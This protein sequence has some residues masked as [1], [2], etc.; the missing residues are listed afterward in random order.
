MAQCN[1][2]T[3]SSRCHPVNQLRSHHLRGTSKSLINHSPT[4]LVQWALLYKLT[5]I[6]RTEV[7]DMAVHCNG[8]SINNMQATSA[9]ELGPIEANTFFR[10]MVY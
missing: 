10:Y 8:Y 2:I 7:F 5:K 3:M 6:V 4:P 1:C 9:G